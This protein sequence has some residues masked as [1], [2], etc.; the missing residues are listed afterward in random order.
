MAIQEKIGFIGGGKMG[1]A[2]IKGIIDAGLTTR[3]RI[4]A[5]EPDKARRAF[6]A[7]RFGITCHEKSEP[8]WSQCPIIILAVKP[9]VM[10]EALVPARDTCN[11]GH[12]VISIAAGIT[13]DFLEELLGSGGC[14]II[15]AMPNTP[16]LVLEA[17]TAMSPG[18][19]TSDSDTATALAIFN[20]IGTTVTVDEHSLDAVTG[21]SGSGP[22]Y[23]FSFIE[24]LTDA[25]VKV[26]LS[27]DIAEKLVL[28]TLLGSTRLAMES[29]QHPAQL[30]S[31]V[32]SPGGTTIA[33]LHVLAASGFTGII[34]DAVEEATERSR[35]LGNR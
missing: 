7:E 23:V 17:A 4:M 18:P 25:G 35:E 31:M 14:R 34:M 33:G 15:R 21:L 8:V 13:L 28:Q 1:E 2:L 24:A 6:L 26:G 19:R 9:Q 32:T 16:A 10:R 30:R 29:G 27:R 12:L 22:A 3:D 11:S 20:A 5:S